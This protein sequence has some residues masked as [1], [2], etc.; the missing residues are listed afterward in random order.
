MT[1]LQKRNKLNF[2]RLCNLLQANGF[3]LHQKV[4][5]CNYFCIFT[6]AD[7]HGAFATK[8]RGGL[9]HLNG[10]IAIDYIDLFDKYSR[11]PINLIIPE[12]DAELNYLLQKI[13]WL[14][15]PE[16]YKTSKKYITRDW[17]TEY[18]ESIAFE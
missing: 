17:I 16:G 8:R 6:D 11:C 2:D 14:R 13:M 10:R 7:F 1:E 15:T 3:T 9:V 5:G 12:T 4:D 18:P